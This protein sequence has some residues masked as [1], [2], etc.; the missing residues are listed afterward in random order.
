MVDGRRAKAVD[1]RDV[2]HFVDGVA[3]NVG[4]WVVDPNAEMS[5]TKPESNA[6]SKTHKVDPALCIPSSS[7]LDAQVASVGL[8]FS[9]L[10]RRSL[11]S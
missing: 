10:P 5:T 2:Q 11:S 1:L 8:L 4:G 3:N 9:S 6:G 7:K